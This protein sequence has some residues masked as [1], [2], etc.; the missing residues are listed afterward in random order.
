MVFTN[1][2]EPDDPIV[3]ANDSFLALTGYARDEVLAQPVRFLMAHPEDLPQGEP[4][5][6][7]FCGEDREYPPVECL[8]RDGSPFLAAIYCSPVPDRDGVLIQHF[9]SFVDLSG[10]VERSRRDASALHTL[11]E[12]TPGFIAITE[13]P[14]HRFTFANAAYQ[15]LLGR[16]ELIGRT[17]I[18]VMPEFIEQGFV[19]MLDR[20]Y[21][22]GRPYV[23]TNLTVRL[24]SASTGEWGERILDLVF[25]PVRSGDD[26]VVGIFCEGQDVTERAAADARV[27]ALQAELIHLS[28]VS[29]MGTMATTL[30]HELNQPLTAISNYAAACRRMVAQGAGREPLEQALTAVSEAALRAGEVIRRLRDMTD[31]RTPQRERFDLAPAL[32]EALTIVR[33]GACQNVLIQQSGA[34]DVQVEADRVQIQQVLMNLARNACEA[35]PAGDGGHVRVTVSVE[36]DEAIVS[37]EDSG[38]GVPAEAVEDLFEWGDSSKPEGMGVGLSISRTIIE[39]HAGRIWHVVGMDKGARFSFS[40]PLAAPA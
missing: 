31:K 14:G 28:R 18:E 35:I 21:A 29:A 40:L 39:A 1:A 36:G 6:A 11:Y 7:A 24:Q 34:S 30:A 3:F 5:S 37:V 22:T 32:E 38:P 19:A 33:A 25:Q 17:V 8:R 9:M 27:V 16:R 20:V 10:H 2:R 15:H 12:N 26:A 4:A 23:G 13:G